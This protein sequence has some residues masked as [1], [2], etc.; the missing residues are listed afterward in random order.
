MACSRQSRKFKGIAYVIMESSSIVSMIVSRQAPLFFRQTEITVQKS[1]SLSEV[2]EERKKKAALKRAPNSQGKN[3][4]KTCGGLSR[5]SSLQ[6]Q[7]ISSSLNQCIF[8][9]I[10]SQQHNNSQLVH[11]VHHLVW[12]GCSRSRF[13][14]ECG[15][16]ELAVPTS[17]H[18]P[19]FMAQAPLDKAQFGDNQNP[20]YVYSCNP[21]RELNTL[22]RSV[23]TWGRLN[24]SSQHLS[25]IQQEGCF[26][27]NFP[28]NQLERTQDSS[29]W[30]F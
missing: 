3:Q 2:Y 1:K 17:N 23:S 26:R 16:K 18:F 30:Y 20:N 29:S 13:S 11:S 9:T 10:K 22:G 24:P 28:G 8:N 21:R 7:N 14:S 5:G 15:L 4:K 12:K 27:Y 25:P 6:T 19:G